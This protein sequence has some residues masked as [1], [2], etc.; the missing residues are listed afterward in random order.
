MTSSFKNL[1]SVCTKSSDWNRVTI[2]MPG[3][4]QTQNVNIF[5]FFNVQNRSLY[6]S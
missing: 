5:I 3:F 2:F 1:E 6:A 4:A